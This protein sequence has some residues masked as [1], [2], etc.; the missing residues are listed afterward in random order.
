MNRIKNLALLAATACASFTS[1]QATAADLL[2]DTLTFDRRYPAVETPV[3]NNPTQT[4]T[5]VAGTGDLIDW[6]DNFT[7]GFHMTVDPE[8][9]T[10]RF[11]LISPSSF[12][13]G[14]G[15]FDGF[16]I[17]GFGADVVAVSVTDNSTGL[18]IDTSFGARIIDLNV[19]A[20]PNNAN[21][22]FTL[23]VSVVPEPASAALLLAGLLGVAGVAARRRRSA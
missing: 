14:A 4:T 11:T 23:N 18:G 1:T 15:V 7:T 3:W 2:G 21:S 19:L 12:L 13:G 20:G 17:T 5:V 16:R 8:A 22:G 9:T 10:I 6:F